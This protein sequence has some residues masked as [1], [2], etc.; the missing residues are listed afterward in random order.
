MNWY[1]NCLRISYP[2]LHT[3]TDIWILASEKHSLIVE[4]K[5]LFHL[6]SKVFNVIQIIFMIRNF[7]RFTLQNDNFIKQSMGDE[8]LP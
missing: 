4:D 5:G 8:L 2:A 3:D 6:G 7:H 1:C